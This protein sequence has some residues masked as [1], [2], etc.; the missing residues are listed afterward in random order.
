MSG[1]KD[2]LTRAFNRKKLYVDIEE[3]VL[4]SSDPYFLAFIDGDKFKNINDTYGHQAG[5]EVL[6]LMVDVMF[7]VM[8]DDEVEGGVYRFGGEEFILVIFNEKKN[9]V[10]GLLNQIKDDIEHSVIVHDE[11]EIK[12]TISI[13][14]SKL[15]EGQSLQDIIEISDQLVY[16]AKENGRNRIE[17]IF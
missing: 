5:D 15:Q 13:G 3:Y 1:Y 2:Q 17:Y 14:A 10:L 6:K 11:R 8:K 9:G 16:K 4:N 12:F 7:Q